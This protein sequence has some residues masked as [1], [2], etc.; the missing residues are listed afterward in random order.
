L[1]DV[2]RAC[3]DAGAPVVHKAGNTGLCGGAIPDSRGAEIVVS[4]RRMNRVRALDADNATITVEAGVPTRRR[5][6]IRRGG[7]AAL[8]ALACVGRKL[9]DR[10]Q[11][12][13]NAGG[14]AVL[15]YGNTRDLTLGL[16]AVLADGSV[17]SALRGLRKDNTGTTSSSCSSARRAR[18]GRD[19][20]GDEALPR[21]AGRGH[22]AGRRRVPE[23]RLLCS[24]DSRAR[25]PTARRVRLMSAF[26]L[27]LSR[28]H[29]PRLSG[30]DGRPPWYAWSTPKTAPA[31]RR[32]PRWSKAAGERRRRGVAADATLRNPSSKGS[33]CGR[34]ARTSAKRSGAKG[35]NIKHDIS[36]PVS[37]IPGS[38]ASAKRHC[39]AAFPARASWCSGT[40]ATATFTTTCPAPKGRR[41]RFMDTASTPTASCTTWCEP[42][43]Q[44]QRRARRRAAEADDPRAVQECGGSEVM[45]AIKAVLD[46]GRIM[47]PGKVL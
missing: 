46:P 31:T 39:L 13:T 8:S 19:R 4:L 27:A 40:W 14:T 7:G 3:A 33:G 22:G 16:E 18:S 17:F 24:R 5:A 43:R 37:A 21:A 12:S 28:K 11:L 42:R 38:C 45:R 36:L 34:C 29:S 30:L 1:S 20:G 23:R 6:G 26:S 25:C 41:S 35:P 47:N 15:R 10:R 44:L 2:V 9:H 32:F